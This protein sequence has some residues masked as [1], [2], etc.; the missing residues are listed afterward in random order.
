MFTKKRLKGNA[1]N[2]N[3]GHYIPYSYWI[4]G[5][6]QIVISVYQHNQQLR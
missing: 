1:F 6:L 3:F 5:L 4:S 2:P